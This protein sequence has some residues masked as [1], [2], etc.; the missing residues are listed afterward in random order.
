MPLFSSG[1]LSEKQE[2]FLEFT[3]ELLEDVSTSLANEHRML[4]SLREKRN[5]YPKESAVLDPLIER[6]EGMCAHLEKLRTDLADGR[7]C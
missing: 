6:F 5:R 3:N 7:R 1:N 2:A 4:A